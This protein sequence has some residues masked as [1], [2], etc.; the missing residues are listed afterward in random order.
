MAKVAQ[1]GKVTCPRSHGKLTTECTEVNSFDQQNTF[2]P[3]PCSRAWYPTRSQRFMTLRCSFLSFPVWSPCL[4]VVGSSLYLDRAERAKHLRCLG[5]SSPE[6]GGPMHAPW[7]K[8][9]GSI[10][11]CLQKGVIIM[12]GNGMERCMLGAWSWDTNSICYVRAVPV[13]QNPGR[14]SCGHFGCSVLY[15]SRVLSSSCCSP[16]RREALAL[17][18]EGPTPF[19]GSS[20]AIQ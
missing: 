14:A 7:S 9:S 10:H 19:L 8:P 12:H 3:V 15:C 13:S 6:A 16:G 11:T 1:M 2:S 4:L 20:K 17:A 5:L 18:S